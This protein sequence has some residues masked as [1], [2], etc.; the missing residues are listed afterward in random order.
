MET[1][2]HS[3]QDIQDLRN[4]TLRNRVARDRLFL[5]LGLG[6]PYPLRDLPLRYPGIVAVDQDT[7]IMIIGGQTGVTYRLCD[8]EGNEIVPSYEVKP[9]GSEG[10]YGV[11]LLTPKITKDV[12]FSI[13]AVREDAAR[14][15]LL[16]TYLNEL[17]AI[18]VG[19]DQRLAVSFEPL[20]Q[21]GQ[22]ARNGQLVVNYAETSV[23]IA[24]ALSQEGVTYQLF[25]GTKDDEN[26]A[27]VSDPVLGTGAKILLSLKSGVQL[28]E[29]TVIKIK[30]RR[31]TADQDMSVFLDARLSVKV[32]PDP[33]VA[34][35][36]DLPVVD[37][38]G[39]PKFALSRFQAS[40]AYELYLRAV[41]ASEY[42][43]GVVHVQSR[44]LSGFVKLGAF[45][46]GAIASGNLTK[47][48]VF[49]VTATKIENG[50]TLQLNQSVAVLVRPS[51]DPEV[52]AERS[53]ISTGTSGK[54][55]VNK[56]QK[57]VE[58]QLLDEDNTSLGSPGYDYRDRGLGTT[59]LGIDF[60]V[61]TDGGKPVS[62]PTPLLNRKTTFR[63]RATTIYAHQS[64]DLKETVSID[65]D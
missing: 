56:T 45:T 10:F 15:V 3:E 7:R 6:V 5:I 29:D 32:R 65:V 25:G 2:L 41:T 48:T 31:K 52:R 36:A 13:M 24:V 46:G 20:S 64:T 58:Y 18:E 21:R 44:E 49:I 19:L 8:A 57:G 16:E 47:D 4:H 35:S 23:T 17:V 38:E 61:D 34:V 40:A 43:G 1:D 53:P 33:T 9:S 60:G 42:V 22:V 12:T 26:V 62:L 50:E 55:L 27:P 51:R 39:T 28:V 11:T 63:V 30:A 59:R 14:G 54:V 37:Y